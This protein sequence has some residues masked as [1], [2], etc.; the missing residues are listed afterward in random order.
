MSQPK[1]ESRA[2]SSDGESTDG[3]TELL[4]THPT[5][6]PTLVRLGVALT[7][8]VALFALLQVRPELLG[9]AD[10]TGT[11]ALVVLFLTVAVSV[12]YLVRIVVL[13]RTTYVV[14]DRRIEREYRLLYR[15]RSKG[16]RFDKLRSHELTQSRVQSLLGFGTIALNRGLGPIRLDDVPEPRRVYDTICQCARGSE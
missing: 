11:V 4:R 7:V 5:I 14:T 9:S 6:K 3:E 1:S 8:G 16:I 12:R 10:V 2:V 13:R 15:T